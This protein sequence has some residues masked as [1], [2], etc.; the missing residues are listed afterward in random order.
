MI[1]PK[2]LNKQYAVNLKASCGYGGVPQMHA[3]ALVPAPGAGGVAPS[4]GIGIARA[5]P[6][7]FMLVAGVP[8]ESKDPGHR[9]WIDLLSAS[10]RETD[11][12]GRTG[13][14]CRQVSI[15]VIKHMDH[16]SPQLANLAATGSRRDITIDGP[17]GR[18][19][20]RNAMFSSV[21]PAAGGLADNLP[22][23]SLSI[24]GSDCQ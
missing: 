4:G 6:H 1:D 11:A 24:V 12:T 5:R 20:L 15:G 7:E 18:K 9:N 23:E 21:A 19:T 22:R 10:W 17:L 8:G 3:P 16:A 13:G 2:H 14:R